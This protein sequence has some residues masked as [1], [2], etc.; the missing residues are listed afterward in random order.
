MAKDK[1]KT[2]NYWGSV[3]NVIDCKNQAIVQK[4][5]TFINLIREGKTRSGKENDTSESGGF[6][7]P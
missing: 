5:N 3:I 6:L 4:K 2:Q 7:N 1:N